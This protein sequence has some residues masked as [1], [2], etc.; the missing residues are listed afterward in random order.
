M[1]TTATRGNI[2]SALQLTLTASGSSRIQTHQDGLGLCQVQKPRIHWSAG[3]SDTP[4]YAEMQLDKHW[5]KQCWIYNT[6]ALQMI[7]GGRS[8][9][10]THL[11]SRGYTQSISSTLNLNKT[12][13]CLQVNSSEHLS[14]GAKDGPHHRP[15]QREF[16]LAWILDAFLFSLVLNHF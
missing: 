3:G 5:Y 1:V 4:R 10:N 7:Y 14:G 6:W 8:V 11:E 9:L 15:R 12:F 2:N 16:S 13:V